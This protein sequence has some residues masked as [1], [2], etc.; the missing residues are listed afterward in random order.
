M[1]SFAGLALAACLGPEPTPQ[2]IR[3]AVDKALPLLVKGAEGHAEK[4]SC[5]GCHNQAFPMIAFAAGRKRGFELPEN[6]IRD[7]A[8]H[9]HDFL[10]LNREKFTK[11]QG[12]GGQADTAGWALYTLYKAG[13]EPDETTAAVVE[14]FLKRDADK[15]FWRCS[16]NRPPTEAS[17]FT[18]TYLGVRA[19]TEWGADDQK[20][21][22]DKRLDAAREW[23]IK[24]KAR[25]TEDRVFKIRGLN[26]VDAKSDEV[27]AVVRE[28]TLTQRADGGWAQLDSR[29]SDPY[30]TGS[31]LA[32]LHE[33]G[34]MSPQAPAFQR[35]LSYLLRTQKADGSWLVK[36]RSKPFQPYYES[37][38]P[39][40]KNQFISV[41]ASAW[42]VTALVQALPP[43]K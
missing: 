38:F 33:V 20:A 8:K 10:T 22:I 31:V 25:D 34:G 1:F 40:E 2:A 36:S 41:M 27:K 19:L 17:S 30:A 12:T 23:M 24:T 9:V 4:R 42:A 13:N 16:S 28:L 21:A 14:Y 6:L 11:G 5:F 7:Q 37:G 43:V 26:A 29:P 3:S 35:G 18:T 15:A 32:V 39:H